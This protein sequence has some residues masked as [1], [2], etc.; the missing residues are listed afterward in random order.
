[1]SLVID[2]D[3]APPGRGAA[4]GHGL[5]NIAARAARMGGSMSTEADGNRFILTT[6]VPS[7][8]GTTA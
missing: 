5:A 3:G 1:V 6:Y 8:P 4:Q 2:N 7:E